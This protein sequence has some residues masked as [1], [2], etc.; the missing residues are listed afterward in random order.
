MATSTDIRAVVP[1]L[2]QGT[3]Q[4][5]NVAK[6][7]TAQFSQLYGSHSDS[8]VVFS[9][10]SMIAAEMAAILLLVMIL[11]ELKKWYNSVV[12]RYKKI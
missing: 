9:E 3:G 8:D 12:K 1:D 5:I 10:I 2:G 6:D 11:F 7:Q 4:K